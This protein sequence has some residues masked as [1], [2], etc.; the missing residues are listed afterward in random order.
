MYIVS[1]WL[2]EVISSVFLQTAF[3]SPLILR[4]FQKFQILKSFVK[5][6]LWAGEWA[7]A[8]SS[9]SG[10]ELSSERLMSAD[11]QE[12]WRRT[13]VDLSLPTCSLQFVRTDGGELEGS[14]ASS[15]LN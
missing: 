6:R 12:Q 7:A 11:S 2:E 1:K 4:C 3:R 8:G 10:V 15:L 5:S 9:A 14:A 13:E